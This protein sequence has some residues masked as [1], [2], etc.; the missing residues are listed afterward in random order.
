MVDTEA[1]NA[2]LPDL[3]RMVKGG[4]K[5]SWLQK[6]KGVNRYQMLPCLCSWVVFKSLY[7]YQL[8]NICSKI[9]IN[10]FLFI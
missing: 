5:E 6:P 8:Q 2:P 3:G 4:F 10:Q 9:A 1:S 7:I